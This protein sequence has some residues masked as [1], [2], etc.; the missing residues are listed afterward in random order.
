MTIRATLTCI[1]F[2]VSL[3]GQAIATP[4][5]WITDLETAKKEAAAKGGD[6]FI[7]ITGSDW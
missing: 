6:I 4:E 1:L 5:G 2:G 3:A 7:N